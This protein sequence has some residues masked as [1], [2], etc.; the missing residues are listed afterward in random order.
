MRAWRERMQGAIAA[1]LD[2]GAAHVKSA[3][4]PHAGA[5]DAFYVKLPI[6]ASMLTL[7]CVAAAPA[8]AQA[9]DAAPATATQ[10]SAVPDASPALSALLVPEP[11]GYDLGTL[12]LLRDALLAAPAKIPEGLAVMRA[13]GRVLGVARSA[14]V[15]TLFVAIAF[16]LFGPRVAARRVEARLAPRLAGVPAAA[17]PWLA[18]ALQV[19]IATTPP[20]LLWLA[21]DAIRRVTGFEG[22]G[23]LLTG[24]ALGAWLRFAMSVSI[25]RE[26]VVRPLLP[27]PEEHR[28]YLFRIGHGL[29]LYVALLACV[30]ELVSVADVPQDL[31]ALL[32]SLANLG[33]IVLLTL[34]AIRKQAILALLPA[35]P[36]RLYLRFVS[37]LGHAYPLVLAV[38]A[39]TALLG[40]AGYER[41]ADFI[42]I[43]TWALAGLFVGAALLAH[44]LHLALRRALLGTAE[45]PPQAARR[46]TRSATRLLD[47][48]LVIWVGGVALDLTGAGGALRDALGIVVYRLEDGPVTLLVLL[49]ATV[50]IA[51]FVFASRLVRDLLDFKVYPALGVEES[52]AYGCNV[53]L[54][55]AFVIVG[56][57]FALEFVGIGFGAITIFAGALGIGLGFGMQPLAANLSSGLTLVFGR[58]LRK[59]DWVTVGDTIGE[60]E[61]VGMRAT[62]LRTRDDVEYVVPNAQ[63]VSG[64]IVNWTKSSPLVREHLKLTVA[65][66]SDPARV[67]EALLAVAGQTP[68][69][70]PAPA[71]EV[72]LTGLGPDGIAFELVLFVNVK[73]VAWPPVRS[74]LYF[75]ALTRFRELGIPLPDGDRELH[76]RPGQAEILGALGVGGPGPAR[77]PVPGR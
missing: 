72:W 34:L 59:G 39:A 57:L 16:V 12:L 75:R 10:A 31:W 49:H 66:E 11:L 38:T 33:L 26:L 27:V 60:I 21:H 40:W 46:F 63:F 64:P 74:E 15:L 29:A 35:I 6:L 45:Q 30:T 51:V 73:A 50:V 48:L 43:R 44:G 14:L 37:A 22:T 68:G 77:A 17:R 54:H 32:R 24:V 5:G 53:F 52:I 67:R 56:S 20:L 8:H 3:L 41:L 1:F 42:W 71:P 18:A 76:L 23:F 62:S 25:W 7:A 70:E 65:T 28:A 55:Y 4:K 58:A 69:V 47:Y 13:R 36:N 9:P 19:V 2:D 61:E